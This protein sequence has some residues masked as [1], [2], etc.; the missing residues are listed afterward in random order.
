MDHPAVSIEGL[1]TIR[2][3]FGPE[4]T[5]SRLEAALKAKGNAVLARIDHAA[6]AA[7][8]G[9]LSGPPCSSSSATR[10]WARPSCRPARRPASI[11]R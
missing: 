3:A 10:A 1:T 5:A 7:K 11:C 9:W 2:S 6:A 8:A 4:E